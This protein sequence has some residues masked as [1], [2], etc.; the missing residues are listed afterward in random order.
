M[1][2]PTKP[3][4]SIITVCRNAGDTIAET[5]TSVAAQSYEPLEHLIIDGASTDDTV[6]I[7]Q[8]AN[9]QPRIIS[10][11]DQGIYDAMNKG[12]TQAKGTLILYLNADDQL[13]TPGAIADLTAAWQK[14]S[15]CQ[16]CS[17][18]TPCGF[19]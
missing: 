12:L 4:V 15:N 3:Q 6:A 18:R 8:A 7:A 5:L 1:T 10:E 14:I 19:W 17:G 16:N 9:H 13:T 11:P 2:T